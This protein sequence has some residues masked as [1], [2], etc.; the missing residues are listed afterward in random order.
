MFNWLVVVFAFVM[1]VWNSDSW[2]AV[3]LV[4]VCG[5]LLTSGFGG[6]CVAC[7]LVLPFVVGVYFVYCG[8]FCCFGWFRLF[9]VGFDCRLC[10]SCCGLVE[11]GLLVWVCF[12]LRVGCGLLDL[13]LNSVVIS[14]VLVFGCIVTLYLCV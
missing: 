12:V 11:V 1:I 14:F 2:L 4:A 3:V 6:S 10:T 8:L 9:A 7:S 5:L 13:V